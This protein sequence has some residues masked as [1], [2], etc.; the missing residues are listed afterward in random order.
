[1]KVFII[2]MPESGR[3]TVAKALC[4]DKKYRYVDGSTWVKSTFR[5]Q[6]DEE[7]PQQYHD[8]YHTW[9]LDCL[10]RKPNMCLDH[11][12]DA[13]AFYEGVAGEN[14]D[15]VIDGLIGPRDFVNLFNYNEDVVVF[16]DRINN[17]SEYKDYENIGVSV[18]KDYCF[19]LSAADLLVKTRWLEF[20]F[21]IPG[22]ASESIKQLGSKNSVFIVKSIDKV[23]SH[24]KVILL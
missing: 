23:I 8:E 7:H 17:N 5:P 16:L 1:M 4:Q 10:K 20:K 22:E 15:I 6:N 12:T 19:W 13:I 9:F 18:I 11:I 14:I 24:L 3:T 21:Q 2:G